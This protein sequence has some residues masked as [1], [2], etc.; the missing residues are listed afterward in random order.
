MRTEKQG[1]VIE[2]GNNALASSVVLVCRPRPVD[3]LTTSR[4]A[5]LRE[6]KQVFI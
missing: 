6:L 2:I 1:R 3:A 5:F 4:R